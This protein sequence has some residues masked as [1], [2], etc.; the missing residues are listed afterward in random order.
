MTVDATMWS[1]SAMQVDATYV[2]EWCSSVLSVSALL[3]LGLVV[4]RA[5][6][7]CYN[8]LRFGGRQ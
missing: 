1:W 2:G 3:C 8:V 4:V 5:A 6:G 7:W